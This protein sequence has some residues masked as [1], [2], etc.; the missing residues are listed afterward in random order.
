[1]FHPH[2]PP[3]INVRLL[4]DHAPAAVAMFPSYPV[5]FLLGDEAVRVVVEAAEP[6]AQLADP[7][8]VLLDFLLNHLLEL[9]RAH[10]RLPAQSTPVNPTPMKR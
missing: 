8:R 10:H 3:N 4:M 5:Q 9:R 2:T 7:S 6:T 1:M